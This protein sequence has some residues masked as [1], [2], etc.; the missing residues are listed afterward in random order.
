M[1]KNFKLLVF[2]LSCA[3]SILQTADSS[4]S[5]SHEIFKKIK[6]KSHHGQYINSI[7]WIGD[8]GS[9]AYIILSYK[10]PGLNIWNLMDNT[11]TVVLEKADPTIF[12]VSPDESH[13]AAWHPNEINI[14]SIKTNNIKLISKIPTNSQVFIWSPDSKKLAVGTGTVNPI[15]KIYDIKSGQLINKFNPKINERIDVG[16]LSIKLNWYKDKLVFFSRVEKEI[17]IFNPANGGLIK[18][19]N[20]DSKHLSFD[21]SSNGLLAV[22]ENGLLQIFDLDSDSNEPDIKYSLKEHE[23]SL[24]SP[25]WS[26]DNKFISFAYGNSL[27]LILD[28]NSEKIL[29]KVPVENITWTTQNNKNVFAG[30]RREGILKHLSTDIEIYEAVT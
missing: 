25:R 10:K 7:G 9:L 20:F 21:V 13:I 17:K 22:I 16:T 2:I 15:I 5:S 11:T 1:K 14:W 18:T 30:T 24:G 28:A 27:S 29:Q 12:K 6:T 3:F 19:Y 8:F 23:L 26:K 4:S